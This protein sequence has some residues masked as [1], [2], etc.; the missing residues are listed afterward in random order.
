MFLFSFEDAHIKFVALKEITTQLSISFLTV[1][2]P[3]R[4]PKY[5][6]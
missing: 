3:M 2:L 6:L 4:F 1:K 5:S